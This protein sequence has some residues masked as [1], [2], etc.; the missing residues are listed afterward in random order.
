MSKE[1]WQNLYDILYRIHSDFS[2]AYRAYDKGKNKKIRDD[3]KR[4]VDNAITLANIHISRSREAYELLTGG[5]DNNDYGRA[6]IYEEFL[7]ANYFGG[8][9]N[10]FLILIK[11][12]IASIE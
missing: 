7:R 11:E 12:R 5:P 1:Q 2:N 6:I 8:D 4:Q 3:A 9:M 10:K